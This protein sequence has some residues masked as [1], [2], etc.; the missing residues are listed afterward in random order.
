MSL[1]TTSQKRIDANRRNALRSTGP[2]TAEGKNQSRRNGLV[3]GLAATVVAPA[4][5]THVLIER[6]AKWKSALATRR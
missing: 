1:T 2:K 6:A 3:H 5:E 4:N